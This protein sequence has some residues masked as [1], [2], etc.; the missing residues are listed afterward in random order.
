M[1][2]NWRPEDFMYEY[3]CANNRFGHWGSGFTAREHDGRGECFVTVDQTRSDPINSHRYDLLLRLPQRQGRAAGLQRRARALYGFDVAP[4]YFGN[5]APTGA[6]LG[7]KRVIQDFLV[8]Q[9]NP[10]GELQPQFLCRA[11]CFRSNTTS[12]CAR[13]SIDFGRQ[14]PTKDLSFNSSRASRTGPKVLTAAVSCCGRARPSDRGALSRGKAVVLLP[15]RRAET[16]CFVA[17]PGLSAVSSYPSQSPT[18]LSS[19]S[20][21]LPLQPPLFT[22]PPTRL[23]T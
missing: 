21:L 23:L 3:A 5:V 10:S 9:N 19:S 7:C 22:H 20:S 18:P 17:T 6:L 16:A 1:L 13:C 4:S 14:S 2:Y 8:Y 11:A 12:T 15:S